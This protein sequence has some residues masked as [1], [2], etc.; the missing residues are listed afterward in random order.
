MH[1]LKSSGHFLAFKVTSHDYLE[2]ARTNI[3]NDKGK[4]TPSTPR[5]GLGHL[6]WKS[7]STEMYGSLV[8]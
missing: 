7:L 3:D 2:P 1:I 4:Y 6:C 5:A 8:Y